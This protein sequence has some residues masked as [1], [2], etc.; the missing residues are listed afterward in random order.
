[1]RNSA[2]SPGLERVEIGPG[3]VDEADADLVRHDLAVQQPVLR[4]GDLHRLGEQV[5][6]LDDLDAP[7]AHL[8]HEVGVVALGVLDPHHVVEEQVVAVA[9][10][11]RDAPGR[12]RRPGPCAAFPTSEWTPYVPETLGVTLMGV[13]FGEHG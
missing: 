13:P 2:S 12:A 4:P 9:G 5:V 3:R 7:V 8:A 6:Q 10:V 11:S 1:M